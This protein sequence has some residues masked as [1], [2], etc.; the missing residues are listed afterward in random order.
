[1]YSTTVHSISNVGPRNRNTKGKVSVGDYQQQ[2]IMRWRR[3]LV[4]NN[5]SSSYLPCV[6]F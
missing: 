4:C 2:D 6:V 5:T 1:M 3:A